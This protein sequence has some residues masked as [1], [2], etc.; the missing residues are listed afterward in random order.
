MNRP[1]APLVSQAPE[2][3]RRGFIKR[4]VAGGITVICGTSLEACGDVVAPICDLVPPSS[5]PAFSP[6]II[7][8]LADD[9]GYGDLRPYGHSVLPTPAIETLASSGIVAT[10]FYVSSPVCSP[11]RASLMTGRY[12][13][14]TTLTAVLLPSD[15]VGLPPSEYTLAE[16]LHPI[17]YATGIVGK[18]HLGHLQQHM[19]FNHGFDF[20]YGIPYS[21]DLV[22]L[23]LF[24]DEEVVGDVSAPESQ[25]SLMELFTEAAVGFIEHHR[26]AP[27]FLF[28]SHDAPHVPLYVPQA[29]Q[30]RSGSG[31]YGDMLLALDWSV[32][33]IIETLETNGLRQKTLVIF[34]SDN[35]PALDRAPDG[36]SPAPFRGGKGEVAEGGV[37]V[38]FIA[39]YPGVIPAGR[40]TDVPFA[41]V[42]IL[43]TLATACGAPLPGDR[44]LDGIDMWPTMLGQAEE[45]P[46]ALYFF[47][48]YQDLPSA[49]RSGE[50]KLNLDT[51]RLFHLPTDARETSDMAV[52]FARIATQLE[53]GAREWQATATKQEL[54]S[55]R[56]GC[57]AG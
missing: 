5:P 42:D 38:P 9:L 8:I 18:W 33:R 6:N 39:S 54:V 40:T 19:P 11:S 28:L 51:G 47:L 31:R 17:G 43:P 35:G 49:V 12:P 1:G 44:F 20:F 27:F 10:D 53:R 23:P 13:P 37:R 25:E 34:T 36:G 52:T 4:L 50:W 30:G 46:K 45:G 48:P 7:L 57:S 32:G 21:N 26:N 29:F 15:T 2:T 14:R 16:V 24:R 41:S 3:S 55:L 56:Y 22:P